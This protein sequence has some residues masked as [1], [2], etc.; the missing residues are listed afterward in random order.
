MRQ[1]L[2]LKALF[3]LRCMAWQPEVY[4]V[5]GARKQAPLCTYLCSVL[6]CVLL[7]DRYRSCLG[8][9]SGAKLSN[10]LLPLLPL[11]K[12][13]LKLVPS[14]AIALL[15]FLAMLIVQLLGSGSSSYQGSSPSIK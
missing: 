1:V 5:P 7:A 10:T 12:V 2:G 9:A 15:C 14:F 6:S 13:A 11:G 8:F 3:C 4:P